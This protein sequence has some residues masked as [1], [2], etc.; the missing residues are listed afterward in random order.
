MSMKRTTISWPEEIAAAV[1]QE[2]RRRGVSVS[3]VVRCAV[4]EE[5]G[6]ARRHDRRFAWFGVG[7]SGRPS[8]GTDVDEELEKTWASDLRRSMGR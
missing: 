5:L 4:A 3:E 1:E 2:A 8:S 6:S 7:D